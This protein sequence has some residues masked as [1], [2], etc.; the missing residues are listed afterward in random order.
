MI[1]FDSIPPSRIGTVDFSRGVTAGSFRAKIESSSLNPNPNINP[2][3]RSH[4]IK[5]RCET[6]L[7]KITIKYSFETIITLKFLHKYSTFVRIKSSRIL[8]I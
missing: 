5:K 4:S 3:P 8:E 6:K 1:R 7:I 2:N